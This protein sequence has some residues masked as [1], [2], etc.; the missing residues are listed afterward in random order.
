MGKNIKK[1]EMFVK[2]WKIYFFKK[3]RKKMGKTKK[4]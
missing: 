1:K 2:K 4:W 3:V